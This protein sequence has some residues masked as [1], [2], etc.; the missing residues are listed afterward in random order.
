MELTDEQLGKYITNY[1]D[2]LMCFKYCRQN[3]RKGLGR[4][5]NDKVGKVAPNSV[6]NS[7]RKQLGLDRIHSEEENET[8]EGITC[9]RS[10]QFK[11]NPRK[12]SNLLG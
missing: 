12:K 7:L 2:R 8:R 3:S 5:K 9:K 10:P 1:G 11:D 6:L 4:K